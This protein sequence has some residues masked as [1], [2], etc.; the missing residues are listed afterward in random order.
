MKTALQNSSK[1]NKDKDT[2]QVL[3]V[4]EAA[5]I[6]RV[7]PSTLRR[8]EADNQIKSFRAENGYRFFNRTEVLELKNKLSEIEQ[9]KNSKAK[10]NAKSQ[11]VNQ[12]E[13]IISTPV[14]TKP[15]ASAVNA[16]VVATEQP[17][18]LRF[19]RFAN[20]GKKYSK[21]AKLVAFSSLLALLFVGVVTKSVGQHSILGSRSKGAID[22]QNV[23]AAIDR[24][25]SWVF[26]VRIPAV[27]RENVTA[28]KDLAVNGA[29]EVEGLSSLNGGITTNNQDADLGTGSLTVGVI[30]FTGTA[31]INN[32]GAI[33]EITET[34][35]EE[36]LDLSGDLASEGLNNVR[37]VSLNGNAIG[38]TTTDD[39]N[40]FMAVDGSWES[41]PQ[42]DITEL[43]TITTGVWNGTPIGLDFGGTGL[44]S[45]VAGDML[46]ASDSNTLDTL[47]IG[48]N[49]YVMTSNGTY[50]TWSP[51]S[52]L[53]AT[54]WQLTGN[55]G[56][57][58]NSDF[59]GTT[60]SQG[61][62]FRTNNTLRAFISS[63][64]NFGIGT[65]NPGA[66]LAVGA[67]S[68]F[69]VDASGNITKINNITYSFPASQATVNGQVLQNDGSGNLS[70]GSVVASDVASD[71]LDW[72]HFR[73]SM[74]L[75]DSTAI[76][77]FN[78]TAP[79]NFRYYDSSTSAEA[80]FIQGGTGRV[81][82]GSVA[83]LTALDVRGAI[84]L[85][86][87]AA[88]GNQL[89]T[90]PSSSAPTGSL[91]WGSRT[92]IDNTS[93]GNFLVSAISSAN[94]GITLS[95]STG[96]VTLT[97]DANTAGATSTTASNSGLEIASDGLR[98]IGGCANNEVLAWDAGAARWVCKTT[99]G[100][101]GVTGSGA[102]NQ[103]TFWDG[104][105]SLSSSQDL[106]W[107]NSLGR[108]G[109]G[110]TNPSA[111]LE[112]AGQFAVSSTASLNGSLILA[113]SPAG[114][115]DSVLVLNAGNQ[116][117]ARTIDARV[118]G[119]TLI[120]SSSTH[121]ALQLNAGSTTYLSLNGTQ[122]LT[123]SAINLANA[124]NIS[125]LL[126]TAN[127]GTGVDGSTAPAG[128]LFI[129]TG[130]GFNIKPVGGDASLDST[131]TLTLANTGVAA[132]TYG[133]AFGIP[134]ITVDSKG[135]LTSASTSPLFNVVDG[136][137][138]ANF[139]AR[140]TDNNTL[141]TGLAYD[142]G[143]Q[144]G[145]G[146]QEPLAT[147][148]VRGAVRLGTNNAQTNQLDTTPSS[149]APTGSLY[150]GSRTLI[151]DIN[152]GNYLSTT[153]SSANA[154]LT[155]S[156]A[157]GPVNL[158]LDATTS[159][160]TSTTA[161]NSGLEIA[162]DGLRLLGGCT[163]NQI[164]A[165]DAGANRWVCTTPSSGL[166]GSG[167]AT[168]IAFW[169]G[170]TSLA[171]SQ[172]LY[173]DN[174]NGRLGLGNS[175]PTV[176]LDVTGQLAVSSTATVN[177]SLILAN[178]PAGTTDTVLVLNAGNQVATRSIDARV[179]G[180]TLIDSSS[181]HPALQLAGT[182]NYLS[183]NGTQVLTQNAIDLSNTANTTNALLT[184]RGGLGID[185]STA[186]SGTLIIATG[187]GFNIK[188]LGGDASIDSTGTLTL[189]S[190]GVNAAAYGSALGIPVIT[191]D[192][193]GR[194]TAASTAPL[195]N[196]LDGT[197]SA[198]YVARFTDN[199]TLAT[200]IG[201][202]NGS[203]FGV[204]STNPTSLF[205]VGGSNQF[206]VSSSGNLVRIN[207]VA[208]S[209]PGSQAT[210]N[211]QVLQ[212]DG[213][214]NLS[215]GS[216]VASDV[217]TDSLD[218]QHFRDSMTL[219]DNT[220]INLYNGTAP[221]N[222]RY[223]NSNTSAEAFYIDGTNAR[224]GL[225]NT[226]P[227]SLLAVGSS[228][229]FRVDGTGNLTRINN[230][231]YSWPATQATV[232]GQVLQND[233][234][235]N[236]TWGSVVASDVAV[237]SLDW[238]HFKDA[239]TLDDSTAINLFNG[240]APGNFRY[241]N[242]DNN[243]EAFFIDGG[244]SKIGFGTLSPLEK[245]DVRGAIRLGANAAQGNQLNT[246]PSSS[247]PT[248]SLYW[249]SRTILDNVNAGNYIAQSIS[250]A[251]G[252]ITVSGATGP[253]TLTLDATTA[254]TTSTTASNSGLEI[255]S[256][257][258]RLLGGCANN[259]LLTWDAGANRW[260]CSSTSSIGGVTGSGVA[261]R[262]AFWDGASSLA[263]S[264]SLYWDNTNGRLGIGTSTPAYTVDVNGNVNVAAGFDFS[265][266]NVGLND[267][268]PSNVT[269]G[270][271]LIGAFDEFTYSTGGTV[272]Q[273]LKD[274]DTRLGVDNT[275]INN[276]IGA[277]HPALSLVAGST[278]YLSLNS[279]AQILTA[280]AI[281]LGNSAN[282]SGL[283][284]TARGGTGL[285][286]ST[287]PVGTILVGNGSGF[288][289]RPVNGDA[290]IDSNAV[291]TL[292]NT[293]V[294]A[295]TY[296]SALGIPV[297]TVDSKGR[298]TAASTA[299]VV[300]I[301]DGTGITNYIAKFTDSNTLTTGLAYD[302][303]S[304]FGLGTTA[305]FTTL[306]V[307]GAIR[308]G[309]NN[310]QAN[311]LNTAPISSAP[312]NSL[313]WG[314]RTILDDVNAGNYIVSTMSS[315]NGGITVSSATGPV[316][317]T[318]DATTSGTTSTTAS[319][320]GLEIASDGVRLLGGCSANQILAWDSGANRW[321]CSSVGGL[322]ALSGSGSTNQ[323]AFWSGASS[324][325][326][327]DNF[328]WNSSTSKLGLGTTAPASRLTVQ[329][330]DA[331]S[332]QINPFGTSAGN[333]GEFRWLEL[334]ANGTNYTGF[335]SPDNLNTDIIYTLPSSAGS[336]DYVLTYQN[337][338]VL[339]WKEVTGIGGAG[340]IT[341]VGS[342]ASGAA[343]ADTNADDQW[344]GLGSTAG[345]IEFD[346]QTIDEINFLS[347]NIGIGTTAPTVT[348]DVVGQ[349]AV[350][351]TASL[352]G[353]L[354][355]ANSPSGTTNT[356][357]TLNGNNQVA[358][359]SID[360]TAWGNIIGTTA[361]PNFVARFINADTLS[362]GTLYDNGSQ[363]GIGTQAPF[364]ALDIR[365][366]LR[367]GA[368]A[369]EGNQLNTTPSGSAPTS[370]LYWGS[371]TLIDEVNAGNYIAT[372]LSSANAGITLSGATGPITVTLDATTSGSSSTTAS[373]S[374]LEIA[375]DGLR[376]IGGC[377]ANQILAWDA[378][379]NRWQCT[380][381]SSG[382]GGS[383]VATR[384]AFWN[385]GT[386]LASSQDLYWDNTN[387]RLGLGNS[388]PTV[389]LDV[390]GQLAVSSTATV[391]G[392]LVLNGSPAGTTDSVLVFNTGNQIGARTI[393]SRVWGSTLIDSSSTHPALQLNA[394]STTY[395]SLN[396]T[397]VLTAN[398][399]DLGNA[400]NITGILPAA[401]G[402][403]G[404]IGSTAPAGT[405]LIGTGSGFNIK[406][407][408][409]DA[410][411]DSTGTLT[412]ANTGVNAATYG[413]ALGIPVLTVDSKGRI[414]A[415]STA[416]IVNLIDGT[417]STNYLA[418]WTD[419]NTLATGLAYD[420]GSQFGIGTAAP[421][422][423]LDV[424]GAI[425]LGANAA[426]GNQLNTT[427]SGS[428]PTN[429]LY[430]GSRTLIDNVN[431]SNYITSTLTSANGGI[432]LS[433]ATGPVTLTLD[434]T[435]SGTTSTTASNSG[436]EIASD[437][438]RLLGGC[439]ANQVL[440]WDAG[441]N[442]WVC[443]TPSS[444]LGGSGVATRIAFWNGGTSLASSQDLYWDNTNGRLG[445]GNSAP[446]VRLDI[447]GQLAV[448]STAT[449]NGS[450]VLNGSPAG[451]TDSVLVFNSGNQVG[452]RTIDSRVW[453]SILIDSSSTH[454]ALQLNAGSTTYLSLNS[455][456]VLTASA[457]DLGNAANITGVLPAA[458][459]GTGVNGATA[460]AGTLVIGTGSG[461]NIKPVGGDATIDSTGT[462]TLA[463]TGVSAGTYGSAISVPVITVDS[464]G[465]LT[466]ATT[467]PLL[468]ILDGTGSTNFLAKWTDTN[469]LTTG[470]AYDNGSQ[471]G[472]GTQAP[473]T[474]LDVRGA[475]RLG[476]NAAEGNQ[477][478]TTPSG[479][480]PTYSLYWGS[481]T[482]LDN[483]NANNYITS[484]LTSANA[485]ITLSGATGPVTVTLDANT[486]G[487]TSTTASNSGLE[488]ASDG[489]RLLGGCSANQVLA[490]DAGAN[491]W[492]CTSTATGTVT[493]TGVA[494]RLA[495]WDSATNIASSQSLYWDNT[496]GRLG[497]GNS[498][499]NATLDV[500]G[501]L[502]VSSTATINGAMIVGSGFRV[503]QVGNINKING[504]A[505]SFP[506]AQ[507]T[508][509]GQV[510]TNDG[511]GGLTWG[512]VV[513]S[514]VAADSLDW[515]HFRDN[516][517]LDDNTAINL[518]NNTAPNN[519]RLYNS[520]SST[521]N[522]FIEGYSGK[523][524]IGT[525]SPLALLDVRGAIRLGANSAQGNVLN[526]TPSSSAPTNSLYWGSRTLIDN[527]N[528]GNYIATTLT[529]ANG[530]ITLSGATGPVTLTLDAT[531]SGITSTT[532]SNSGLEIASDGLRLIGGCSAN[533]V[534]TWDAG[535]NRWQCTTPSSGLGGTGVATRIAFWDGGTSLA[536]SQDLYWDNTNGRLG[537]GN[538]APTVRLDVTGQ[539]A[540][541]STATV[542]G[543][544]VLNGSPAGTTD[545]VL[546]FNSG[547]QVGSRTIDSRVWGLTL[548][549]SSST[550]P[551]LQLNAG[552]T[553]YLSLNGTQVLTASAI[554]LGN[555]ANITGVLPAAN[556]G[557]GVNGSTAPAGTL[558]IG[559]G[560][561]FNIKPLGGDA[562]IDSTGT[563]TLAN[564]GVN[565]G[566][567]GS[568]ISVPVIT[569]DSKGRL[570]AATTAPL[571][572]VLD[573]TGIANYI[574]RWSDTNT[575]T[576]GLAYDN[577]SQFGI[578]TQAPFTALD[579]RG[580]I[581]LGANAAQ[582]NQL[583]TTP[584]SSAPTNS[585]YWGSRTLL[586]DVNAGNYIT[587]TLTSANGGITLSGAT[588]PVT[589]TLD[590][591]TS[592]T[593]STTASNSGLE[594][595]SDGLRLL[596]GCSANQV[597]TWDAG[598]NRWNCTTPTTG[599]VT[600][601]GVATRL[602]F[603][604][605]ASSI[606]SSQ[607]LYWDNTNLRLGIGTSSPARNLD[608]LGTAGISTNI[609]NSTSANALI[610]TPTF[611]DSNSDAISI[612][613]N[614]NYIV[615]GTYATK[616]INN[617]T[618]ATGSSNAGSS[619]EGINNFINANSSSLRNAAITGIDTEIFNSGTV[620]DLTG[621]YA[622][623]SNSGTIT[624]GYGMYI[625]APSNT[626]TWPN[627]F[628]LFVASQ[629]NVG[630]NA[631]FNIFSAGTTSKNALL[632]SL[633][634]GTSAPLAK[635]HVV[636]GDVYVANEKQLNFNNASS[637][638][639][640]YVQGNLEVD[641][642]IFGTTASLNQINIGGDIL[643]DF[644]GSTTGLGL[645]GTTLTI[646]ATT[647]GTTSTTSSNSGLEIASDG[648]RL[649]GG[650]SAN[651]VLTWDAGA[652]RWQC[653]TPTTGTVSGNGV[654]TRLAFW[655]GASSIASSQ[656]L[657]WNNTLGRLGIGNSSP[658]VTLDVTGQF[659]VSSTASLNGPVILASP[660]TGTTNNVLTYES[661]G[662]ISQR[663]IDARV[664]GTTLID[665]SST[666]PALQ[667]A[668]TANYLSLNGTQV[669]T[670][671]AIDLSNTNNTTNALL[672][673][674]GGLGIDA[675]TAPSGTLIVATGSGFN[676]KPLGGD[677]T[678]DS[679]GTLT[680]ANTGVGAGTY[681]SAISVPVITVDS[682]GRLTAAA[683][684][685]LI[686]I[687]D[688]TGS[689][690]YL[691]KWTD[692]NT[693]TTGLA[694]D[695]G[696][697]F[698]IG[699][700]APFTALDVRGAI[701]LGANAAQG[702]QLNTT[703]SGSAPTNSLY[704]G[705]RTLLDDVNAGNYLTSSLTSANGG[706][707][708]SGA[709]GPVTLTLDASTAGITSTTASNSGLE[710][711]SDGLR[712]LGGCSAN[713]VL[714]WD[715][716]ANRWNCTT[717]NA[718]TVT[719]SGVA[720]RLAFWNGASSLA[721]SQ[722]L[723]WDN[724]NMRLG[725]GFSSPERNLDLAGTAWLRGNTSPNGGLHIAS[726]GFVGVGTTA[727]LYPFH[728]T[729]TAAA[730]VNS[731][732][733]AYLNMT[734]GST[735]ANNSG[736]YISSVIAP[737]TSTAN[738]LSH[739]ALSVFNLSATSYYGTGNRQN[740][741]YIYNE[742]DG[743]NVQ[744]QRGLVAI[745]SYYHSGTVTNG[746]GIYIDDEYG[747]GTVNNNY[748]LN[749][750]DINAGS[751]DYGVAIEGADTQVL[752]LGS[753]ADN[754]DAANGIA[755]GSSRDTNLYRSNNNVLRTDDS[756]QVGTN[757]TVTGT[758]TMGGETIGDFL[759]QGLIL[760][761]TAL[762]LD[763]VTTGTTSTTAS[764]SGLELTAAGLRILGGCSANQVLAWDAGA[765]RWQC[766]TP[767]TGSLSG[768]GVA[769]RLA[770][771]DGA[772]SLASSQSLYWDNNAGRLGIGTSSPFTALDIRG[773]IRLGANAAEG[774]QLNTTP[775]SSAPTNSLYWG[776]RTL[777]D[778]VN[779]GNYGLLS[780]NTASTGLTLSG[781]TG[782]VTLALD[783]NT[784][785]TTGTTASNSGL[786][787]DSSGLRLLGGCSNNQSLNWDAGA[788]RWVCKSDAYGTGVATR[789]AFWDS[790]NT[791][792]SN[793]S[794]YWDNTNSRL[795]IGNSAPTVT[796]D[797]TGQFAVSSTATL[798]GSLIL[799]NSPAG[800][801]NTIL[802][803]NSGNQ[804]AT[805]TID[806]TAW[807]NIIGTTASTNFVARFI[808]ADTLSTGTLYDNG[809]QVGIGTQ[810]PFTALDVRGAI[811]LGANAAEGN[812]LNTTPSSSAPTN[813]LY[814]GSRT[815]LDNSNAG[816]YITTTLTSAN[817][818]I[819]LSGATGPVTLTL[820]ATTAGTTSTTASNSGL[821]IAS[822]GLRLLGGCSANQVLSWDAGANRWRCV[823][824]SGI[825][826]VTGTGVATRVAFW[827]S[828]NNL[829]SNQDLYWNNSLG[830]LGIGTSAPTAKRLEA[831]YISS[832][833]NVAEYAA[834][835]SSKP[836][837]N[838]TVN[839]IL[840][841]AE[842]TANASNYQQIGAI[843][844]TAIHYGTGTL[845]EA[846]GSYNSVDSESSGTITDAVA[847]DFYVVAGNNA[848]DIT[849]AYGVKI[850]TAG[851]VSTTNIK[852]NF[853]LYVKDQYG[854]AKN[855]SF[856]IYSDGSNSLNYFGGNVGIGSSLPLAKLDIRGAV[857]LGANAAQGNQLN[858]T[859]SSS[860]P[861][862][863][864]YWGSRTLLDNV[865]LGNYGLL[866]LNT[867]STGL[868]LSGATGPVTLA[869]DVNTALT[870][871][872]T[873]SNSGLEL[874][875]SGLR[876]LGG[877]LSNQVLAWDAGANRWNC[878]SPTT[879]T[880]TGSG[881]ATR[882]AF[883][884]GASS[885]ASSQDLYWDNSL[886][887]LGIGTSAPTAKR[888]ELAYTSSSTA[889]TE[890][891]LNK[892]VI[893]DTGNVTTGYDSV[894]GQQIEINRTNGASGSG[895]DAYGQVITINGDTGGLSG[896]VG[897]DISITGTDNAY[898]IQT[899]A[900]TSGGTAPYFNYFGGNF[901][902]T[903][904]G[905]GILYTAAGIEASIDNISTGTV[906]TAYGT[907]NYI[908]NYSGGTINTAYGNY[909]H[910]DNSNAS[911]VITNGYGTYIN[912]PGSSG[913]FLNNF[914]IFVGDQST[915][916]SNAS[917][918]IYS[919]GAN[920]KN[921]F[922]GN[923]GIGSSLP[924]AKLDIRGA[925]RL[926]ANAAQG[927][928]LNTTP[929]SSAPTN[930]LYWG[931]RT[932][933]DNVNVGNYVPSSILTANAGISLSGATG[934]V[935]LTLDATTT[936]TSSTTA[937]NSGLEI[938][939]SGLRLLG[940]CASGQI[941][942]W[943]AGANRWQCSTASGGLAG[944]GVATRLAFWDGTSSLASSQDL[945]WD[946]TNKRLG[947]G[948]SAPTATLSIAGTGRSAISNSGG[949][950]VLL[951]GSG[952][953]GIGTSFPLAALDI[954]GAVRLGANAAQGNQLN[955]T[956]SGSAPTNSLYWGSRTLLDN[957]NLSNYGLLSLTTASTGLVMNGVTGPATI[958][959]D[960]T[961]AL[962]TGTTA[963]NSGLEL[964]SSGL[965]LLGGCSNNNVLSWDAGANR[966]RCTA[967][968]SG[969]PGGT[970]FQVQYNNAG[971]FAGSI[972]EY[973]STVGSFLLSNSSPTL[974]S[975]IFD[976]DWSPLTSS[977]SPA[978]LFKIN[979]GSNGS[980]TTGNAFAIYSAGSEI[981]SIDQNQGVANV[982]F[983]F[984][985]AG[986]V[987]MA[988]DLV[989][990]NQTSSNIKSYG[991]L[992]IESGESFESNNL[993]L[994]T[995]GT[996]NV[997]V[998]LG[999]SASTAPGSLLVTGG[1000]I[1001]GSSSFQSGRT[1002]PS[1003]GMLVEGRVG[1004]GNTASTGWPLSPL[1005]VA[1006]MGSSA[1007]V[1008]IVADGSGNFYRQSSSIRFKENVESLETDYYK[1009]LDLDSVS[1010]NYKD[1011]GVYSVGYIAEE[1012]DKLNLPGF[1013]LYNESGQPEGLRYDLVGFYLKEVVKDQKLKIDSLTGQMSA[1014]V[1015]QQNNI[1016]STTGPLG[1017]LT[1018][1019]SLEVDNLSTEVLGLTTNVES[1020]GAEVKTIDDRVSYI[1021]ELIGVTET[1022]ESTES[1023]ESANK[1024]SALLSKFTQL[1025]TEI[1026]D[1027]FASLG[1028][1029]NDNGTLT[1030][1031]SDLNVLG[1032]ATFKDLTITGDLLA[1033]QIKVDTLQNSIDVLGASCHNEST[1034]YT[1035]TELCSAQ[1036]LYLQK[1037][1038]SG[1039]IDLFDGKVVISPDGTMA[1040]NGTI[1041]ANTVVADEYQVK[1042]TSQLVGS[1043]LLVLGQTQVT[1044]YNTA[1045]KE[1046]SKVF[1047][1048]ATSST[1049]GQSLIVTQKVAGVSFNVA[1050]DHP[1051]TADVTFD[1052][1053]I[1054][1055]VEEASSA[1056][1057]PTNEGGGLQ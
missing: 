1025:Y 457:I 906:D 56:T 236:L 420:N 976:V 368:N 603:W 432:T 321:V 698:G 835:F 329:S 646:D 1008:P 398:A 367:L 62:S 431:A 623:A 660:I 1042:E 126:P 226:A 994:R 361:S 183:L 51:L 1046:G 843:T 319:N 876:L 333:T 130:S 796:L 730:G 375:S 247:A 581:R 215:W 862:N 88:E 964:D 337:S 519:F 9:A 713:Q 630:S 529:S 879:G 489:L 816:N 543:S 273:V 413:S 674:R 344:L 1030:V 256:D 666:H 801:T 538:S 992:T 296:G 786:E 664:W 977:T 645:T 484:S 171:S 118:W 893:N 750:G 1037:G 422:A 325:T 455:T 830:S 927:N 942:S 117:G 910:L 90:T 930:S 900:N 437:G 165:W 597:L 1054:L 438:L 629:A 846:Y 197:G 1018:D 509:N 752:W 214:G 963:S 149:S 980:L 472:I 562:T 345:R 680:L 928:Q 539:L 59:I 908:W 970:S 385:G 407:V 239:M 376:L 305:P 132:G 424:R 1038:L 991:P 396:G 339:Q 327:N 184:S 1055:N 574:A 114:T 652:N 670:Q 44:S 488:I 35:L 428:A 845:G 63:T 99:T 770:F 731:N 4:S 861:T 82:I 540:V 86:T 218:W 891:I 761:G 1033:G 187:S 837:A 833:T 633:G 1048:T 442:R 983:T 729:G 350:S 283:L 576:T 251:N 896:A 351:S 995:F 58:Q 547:N 598:A 440:T 533:Q 984:G 300:N 279:A 915:V 553:T 610:I 394:G 388:A 292:S 825:S 463:N 947:I 588:G 502:A 45:F 262:I 773:A 555:A 700:Q 850:E 595:A 120:D 69:Q 1024:I 278:T 281:D 192:A 584:S 661:N 360:P 642:T 601:S 110:T 895:N 1051:V 113:N 151:D 302:N 342:V 225:G 783:V 627:N 261:T 23:L 403:T 548:I 7:S 614:V 222:F 75:D 936:G 753:G 152:A 844:N 532:A 465:R 564:T 1026:K 782:P 764:N 125:G 65:S 691:A 920:S 658:T 941:L 542:N 47:T 999:N 957:V 269:S 267:T 558:I 550:H 557:T 654:A 579:V 317:L 613:N 600:G 940:G 277:S 922:G 803:L 430:W 535:A 153:I 894:T 659:A 356:I 467:A 224:V 740:G 249:G 822:D 821:E 373:N 1002:A 1049:N 901:Y 1044:I 352:N 784:A 100:I 769:T 721:S 268:G 234:N 743:L 67:N 464:K 676:I 275:N 546:V 486:T 586:D 706:I 508:V 157:T 978:D 695:N 208:Y 675:S 213:S 790:A 1019:L 916:G 856:N 242:S 32:L 1017:A 48:S 1036:T 956:P 563:L 717:P 255:A 485:G 93:A 589:V 96:P 128:T 1031:N 834:I 760:S 55:T 102:A 1003:Y 378:G 904:Y 776:S 874:D 699:T 853:G 702:N 742:F 98:L 937:S 921:Y 49:G 235:G 50:P 216:V 931:S 207:N 762:T 527:V 641:G 687:L 12:P 632:G 806:P 3:S 364:T 20:S 815:L 888:L 244:A 805:R 349:F 889:A 318:L 439:T 355:L 516:M 513:A 39:G 276:L 544:L 290:S 18:G 178:S 531:T 8:L 158:T 757:L 809:S 961:T 31:T 227:A 736:V 468:N 849:N 855:A 552:S 725:I 92:L 164:L 232:N 1050:L 1028:L 807:G 189:A 638:N 461:F 778:N 41:V 780:I 787:L 925:V 57:N 1021:E 792:A 447:T 500:T 859:P 878:S 814:W 245:V 811:R 66:L 265:V 644:V 604:N 448:S 1020:V 434:A 289:I 193:K 724:T 689:T 482:L 205:T 808:N 955:T 397:Q 929:S 619:I 210:V 993:T 453:G 409:G 866:S 867:A 74:T 1043:G 877:C 573:G 616:G 22:L 1029:T 711:A 136:T 259:E 777:L 357:L 253:V 129:A 640:L 696:I 54:G 795:G 105:S 996:G 404:I 188:P 52:A 651:Q 353:S 175:A 471:F 499:P 95:G 622:W 1000:Q 309:G 451:T 611:T 496:T 503:D 985:A 167:V 383:G 735:A 841:N 739:S 206:Q 636:G 24:N 370:S 585:L 231:A 839:T 159:G 799:A 938:D 1005:A 1040:V 199:N 160:T 958:A 477:L 372:S 511:N 802:T 650:C 523:I 911:S 858:T 950:I 649:L 427:P 943:D 590:A 954:R 116:V 671:N 250:S 294:A 643:S 190:T 174:T 10:N 64:G 854:T 913:T 648:L 295:A 872:T 248:G 578:G 298:I 195:I 870:T 395:L 868:T 965:R 479:S 677:A 335:K 1009:V 426:E 712:L 34:T 899:S 986:D 749:V 307:R 939:A 580:A 560:S 491:R 628:G 425:R 459:G 968:G 551:A 15:S 887:T 522:L 312:T 1014:V 382:L 884:N 817:A 135:R 637:N 219:D 384:I 450:L 969:T 77:L 819:T 779:L 606:A 272:Q 393:D 144:F 109:I 324:I 322:G 1012:A 566:T 881:V 820:D 838:G 505:Y 704:W 284:G 507:A 974:S 494:T 662:Q 138:V 271:N 690:N 390:T 800:T 260:R 851:N 181:T 377:S 287:A 587:S 306:D 68:Q 43:G 304:Q 444:G 185:A 270:T 371:R 33:D 672:T 311:Q 818:G 960:V 864:L 363:V 898:A 593:T 202:D 892:L 1027:M 681:G 520:T 912:T 21:K 903:H 1:S 775:S 726:N 374:G 728:V 772:S 334:A 561:G 112:V 179:W 705:S 122:V 771:W 919:N 669:L 707:T 495:F 1057:T 763:P 85:G 217:A 982:P 246:T 17:T 177:G 536:S 348:L 446:T 596:G 392:S 880:V 684:A 1022:T 591:T 609:S 897:Q 804:V 571:L 1034:L 119:S 582:G 303:G 828:A 27:F 967:S 620:T 946:N 798:N 738:N 445:L 314:S 211:G 108:L 101:G 791:L 683:T 163:A 315:A 617:V 411:I 30:D 882:L 840:S 694:Y 308:L 203:Q 607:S 198:N 767:S 746:S 196:I 145:L 341:A 1035:N 347:A 107:N 19:H 501:Q 972:M 141:T 754:T 514:D 137:G 143:T 282:T 827:D 492:N 537:L 386:S 944:N 744:E 61:L 288:N 568:A 419:T 313:Y 212:N 655:D 228:S 328:W 476:A 832:A 369:A 406:P 812:Q 297:L 657:F 155:V 797:V 755:F 291:L 1007:G 466:A 785:L 914:G 29:L 257:G 111:T 131:G 663:S 106:Y 89:N 124:A 873:A 362:T 81:A 847:G 201:Y 161:S 618:T 608:I 653:A 885:L 209:W 497:I 483:V 487:T 493:G 909:I 918:N 331:A 416:P 498:S 200:G 146:T 230:I 569:V 436:L 692:T 737:N 710:I 94:A 191:V 612:A 402:G 1011:T 510:L 747:S 524:G 229:Q 962:T 781:A 577:G 474:A 433:G 988:Y 343:F 703:P 72:A 26:S 829:A 774:N 274:I 462:L 70:W 756:F 863:S 1041:K 11:V 414:T 673:S 316:T 83:P 323:V 512:S 480:A 685:P 320:S 1032:N 264:Q 624:N 162:S 358:T 788:N 626:G 80:L 103:V 410:T 241:Y 173:W 435:T 989:F 871:G 748:G 708:L 517:T 156:S 549:D 400:A 506:S 521:E 399:I 478:N 73:D 556:G 1039:N 1015:S 194:M 823:A 5:N 719:G 973:N 71:S 429:S 1016:A 932:I 387:G 656:S 907:R 990:T 813:S 37:I 415:A 709:T 534:L 454:P 38:D 490:W 997:I 1006:G 389:R 1053:W 714:A 602:A 150:W 168:R 258:L 935:T 565:A 233:G 668:G 142:N 1013:V 567:Y 243:T 515:A 172:N 104:T 28:E 456:Q 154:G 1045:I 926:G 36:A 679:T 979:I 639:D 263:S 53:V 147:L 332:I 330:A 254:G 667:L 13:L 84:R 966:W 559:T 2:K 14:V 76:N 293:G 734:V 599:T 758:L 732:I 905:Q 525:T 716:G 359:R 310:A 412:L 751:N 97:L 417:G 182:A 794:L 720:T 952:Q 625:D 220:A 826:G 326:G 79:N 647:S 727:Q 682:K 469:T 40:I 869:L 381:P 1004:I 693:L 121:P 987:S 16:T 418:K 127:G 688:G 810:A 789:L 697:Q 953:V 481:R 959:L 170:G 933:L 365:G 401:N 741:I 572:N 865:N 836:G 340:D 860:A 924:L 793:Q 635:L 1047:V 759:G 140:W 1010:Y 615:G 166:A 148:D 528:A 1023:S 285:D 42:T 575:L 934:P 408:G 421:L 87:N 475:I 60:D 541:S 592:G 766:T 252:G 139:I 686:N 631:S 366:A 286:G 1056:A 504:I 975:Y 945:Y 458:N 346:D 998:D 948:T 266:G 391:N 923:V 299:P 449:L 221:S 452:A 723:Y 526:T 621:Y 701:R 336:A 554:D 842:T 46:F 204:G 443:T 134:V 605:G 423:T 634:V 186:P 6:L 78:G 917:F 981:F 857:R 875:S 223:Y 379:A 883:W 91:Y 180:S 722:S 301:L 665:S 1001:I 238:Q 718:G 852:N 971:S 715:A 169:N 768:S 733:G 405:L 280:T 518:F 765:N 441:A 123:T 115:T 594:I 470:L 133:S 570:T 824:L 949:D 354:F 530:G 338:G 1052:Y 902:S 890:E 545:S 886:G 678:I 25:A 237:D 831:T 460:P 176:T 380:T 473:F 951:P 240:T 745:N 583:N 848:S